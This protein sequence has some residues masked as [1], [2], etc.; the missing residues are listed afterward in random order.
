MARQQWPLRKLVQG[1]RV[2]RHFS[3]SLALL[4]APSPLFR[5]NKALH[6]IE[7]PDPSIAALSNHNLS[8]VF[9]RYYTAF[10]S[11]AHIRRVFR[12]K[13]I[14]MKTRLLNYNIEK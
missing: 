3:F 14:Q 4:G 2:I 7:N 13:E 9:T 10:L 12:K 6:F 5:N 11:S 1:N 8:K